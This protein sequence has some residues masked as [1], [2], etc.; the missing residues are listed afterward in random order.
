MWLSTARTRALSCHG[1]TLNEPMLPF[2]QL[3]LAAY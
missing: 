2:V 1:M 3:H